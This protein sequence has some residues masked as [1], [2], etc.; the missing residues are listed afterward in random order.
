MRK[1]ARQRLKTNQIVFFFQIKHSLNFSTL[2]SISSRSAHYLSFPCVWLKNFFV[3]K[4][5]GVTNIVSNLHFSMY[6]TLSLIFSCKHP[7]ITTNNFQMATLGTV[8]RSNNAL[9]YLSLTVKQLKA[10]LFWVR[11]SEGHQSLIYSEP[12]ELWLAKYAKLFWKDAT[13]FCF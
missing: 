12:L 3:I 4:S 11:D 5:K 7:Q 10:L 2:E 13:W 8:R 1:S 6:S 9:E